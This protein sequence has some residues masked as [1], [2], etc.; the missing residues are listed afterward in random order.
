MIFY[1]CLSCA[2]RT[3]CGFRSARHRREYPKHWVAAYVPVR[4]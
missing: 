3:R 4:T 1:R 2:F